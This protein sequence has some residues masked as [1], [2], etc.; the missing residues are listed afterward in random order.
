M[1]RQQK[2]HIK[3]MELKKNIIASDLQLR[4]HT[5]TNSRT[6]IDRKIIKT[7]YDTQLQCLM[8]INGLSYIMCP[9]RKWVTEK[10]PYYYYVF[11]SLSL[12]ERL[13]QQRE[14]WTQVPVL[15][16]KKIKWSKKKIASQLNLFFL[17]TAGNVYLKS[18]M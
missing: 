7:K 8:Y 4:R 3:S 15:L 6:R 9:H 14:I 13:V 12:Q 10:F 2:R 1:H 16:D 18:I 5:H 17:L 11:F